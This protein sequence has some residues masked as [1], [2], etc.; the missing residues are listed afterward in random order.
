[1]TYHFAFSSQPPRLSGVPGAV[2]QRTELYL[3]YSEGAAQAATPQSAKSIGGVPG[4]AR[5]QADAAR[6]L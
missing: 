1:M 2:E 5:Q 3:K 4:F 6:R